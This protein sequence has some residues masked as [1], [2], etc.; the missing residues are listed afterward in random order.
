MRLQDKVVVVTGAGSG[1]GRA[2]TVQCAKEGAGVVG[3]DRN[4]EALDDTAKT[5]ASFK[6]SIKKVTGDAMNR[7]VIQETVQTAVDKFGKLDAMINIVGGSSLLARDLK[8]ITDDIW[9]QV[10]AHNTKPA[11]WGC[12]AAAEIMKPNYAGSIINISSINGLIGMG[13]PMYALAK[14]AV[15]AFTRAVALE[16]SHF[17]IRCNVI[18][19]GSIKTEAWKL[20]TDVN[21]ESYDMARNTIPLKRLGTPEEVAHFAVYLAS[22]ESAFT[23]GGVHVIDGGFTSS[24]LEFEAFLETTRTDV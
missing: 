15:I 6:K 24:S 16:L 13:L 12:Q 23:T 4:G 14:G 2:I 8:S 20:H 18:V 17:N 22:D 3:L 9:E 11:V 5:I 21:P 1:I 10:L 19:P 7:S